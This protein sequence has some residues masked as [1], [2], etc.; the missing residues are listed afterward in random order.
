ME[1]IAN[2]YID[3]QILEDAIAQRAQKKGDKSFLQISVYV[4]DYVNKKGQDV[5]ITCRQTQE[6]VSAKSAL[7]NIGNAK[8]VYSAKGKKAIDKPAQ[9]PNYKK[10]NN[11]PNED[12]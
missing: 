10:Q 9:I 12:Y 1:L 6:E 8:T 5:R 4:N 11:S 3:I 2:G 7:I